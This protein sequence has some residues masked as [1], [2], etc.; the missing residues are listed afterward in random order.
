MRADLLEE[1]LIDCLGKDSA[2]VRAESARPSS[3]ERVLASLLRWF[4]KCELIEV[5]QPDIFELIHEVNLDQILL[6]LG[7][8]F[9]PV[10]LFQ[11][12]ITVADK[13]NREVT[14]PF[15]T[16]PSSMV[17]PVSRTISFSTSRASS[18]SSLT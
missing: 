9:S 11:W 10:R 5:L 7:C 12:Q 3:L 14:V 4:W 16:V 6:D 8:L 17:C 1:V 18:S 15:F 13:P 2:H